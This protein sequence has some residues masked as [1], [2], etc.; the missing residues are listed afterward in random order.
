[1]IKSAILL[2]SVLPAVTVASNTQLSAIG[3]YHENGVYEPGYVN[4]RFDKNRIKDTVDRSPRIGGYYDDNGNF[5]AGYVNYRFNKT[6][7]K[8]ITGTTLTLR[9]FYDDNGIFE[10]AYVNY[11][12]GYKN[13]AN[14]LKNCQSSN[15]KGTVDK[16]VC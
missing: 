1:M 2:L 4:Y 8:E 15:P 3:H 14:N 5:E 13:A 12:F 9:G 6:S 16:S 11:R 10:P 7:I